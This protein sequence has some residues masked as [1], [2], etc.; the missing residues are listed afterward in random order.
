M[1][2]KQFSDGTPVPEWAS[3]FVETRT[4][5]HAFDEVV[6]SWYSLNSHSRWVYLPSHQPLLDHILTLQEEN[7]RLRKAYAAAEQG[8]VTAIN[9]GGMKKKEVEWAKNNLRAARAALNGQEEE[10]NG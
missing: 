8:L 2:D 6:Q 7:E 4:Q 10:K 3:Q 5:K 9:V 1:Q